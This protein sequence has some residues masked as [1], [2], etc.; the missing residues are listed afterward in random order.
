ML[1]VIRG[2]GDLASGIAL[3]LWRSRIRV[4]MTE[5][6][7][8]TAIRR[9]VC[10]SQAVFHG[11]VQVEEVPARRAGTPEEALAVLAAGAIPVL[12]DPEARCLEALHP[13]GLVDAILAKKNLGTRITDAPAVVAAGPGFTAGVDCHA[14]VETMR[15][16]DLG[17]VIWKGSATPT[18]GLPGLIGGF[19]GERVLRAPADGVF[20]Q[21]LDIGAQVKMGDAAA[22]VGGVPM[23]CTLD[24]VLRGILADGIPVRKGMKA[25]D[26]DPRNQAENCRR[27]S[28]KAL[29]VGGGVLE[30]LLALTGALERKD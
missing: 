4:V 10:F 7:R 8:P 16:H 19:A 15:G 26:V 17:R 6:P 28:D 22:E 5:L 1:V 21:L 27:A 9:T 24:G 13:D 23:L 14:V 29:A 2:A 20:H 30:A 25:G 3:R 18:T 12:A 11:E